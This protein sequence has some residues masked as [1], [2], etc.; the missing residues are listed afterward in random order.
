MLI[1][2]AGTAIVAARFYLS[3][4]ARRGKSPS[5]CKTMLGGRVEVNESHIGLTGDSTV[6]GIRAFEDGEPDKP[7]LQIEDV[8][9]D[10]SA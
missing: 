4:P 8:K 3:S 9:A 6:Q 5:V 10:L 7:W 1:V 2:L